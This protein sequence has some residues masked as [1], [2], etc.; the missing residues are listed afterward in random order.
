M[1]LWIISLL[2]LCLNAGIS[3]AEEPPAKERQLANQLA[4]NTTNI[5]KLTT[6]AGVA[7]RL[8]TAIGYIYD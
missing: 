1:R 6:K 8:Q 4:R 2:V 7:F 5:Y 3:Q